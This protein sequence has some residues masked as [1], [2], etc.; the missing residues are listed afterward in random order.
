[1]QQQARDEY[2]RSRAYEIWEQEGRPDGEHERHWRQA[3]E[4]FEAGLAASAEVTDL[5]RGSEGLASG[6]QPGGVT[7]AGGPGQG[8]DSIG[9]SG[10]RGRGKGGV[11]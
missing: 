1:M 11:V 2:V 8:A 5:P 9:A 7:P 10:R 6:L 3:T 4:E